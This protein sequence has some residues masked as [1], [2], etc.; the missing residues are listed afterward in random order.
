MKKLIILLVGLF[1]LSACQ[2]EDIEYIGDVKEGSGVVLRVGIKNMTL[3]DGETYEIADATVANKLKEGD[4]IDFTYQEVAGRESKKYENITLVMIY[5]E[6]TNPKYRVHDLEVVGSK[7]ILTLM[8]NLNGFTK[9]KDAVFFDENDNFYYFNESCLID[10]IKL[11]HEFGTHIPVGIS[12]YIKVKALDT[13]EVNGRTYLKD[14]FY[15]DE[16][17]DA[18]K[19]KSMFEVVAEEVRGIYVQLVNNEDDDALLL[20]LGNHDYKVGEVFKR[21]F[22]YDRTTP[23]ITTVR[24]YEEEYKEIIL[25]EN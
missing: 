18:R 8:L 6:E 16:A 4:I 25:N 3:F 10:M 20:A 23:Q 2:K 12:E 15:F 19:D 17:Y 14:V 9:E 21:A 13:I 5:E 11:N 7:E 22:Y 24:G 1:L